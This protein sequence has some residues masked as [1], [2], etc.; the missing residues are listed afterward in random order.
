MFLDEKHVFVC[1]DNCL[2]QQTYLW[3]S[4]GKFEC[5]KLRVLRQERNAAL[6]DEIALL[7][8]VSVIQACLPECMEV[9]SNTI[10]IW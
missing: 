6:P 1:G 9:L 10:F 5:L 8:P 7:T 4:V 3:N 2:I